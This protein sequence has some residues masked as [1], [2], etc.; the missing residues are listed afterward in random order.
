MK[1]LRSCFLKDDSEI[2]ESCKLDHLMIPSGKKGSGKISRR[3]FFIGTVLPVVAPGFSILRKQ[4]SANGDVTQLKNETSPAGTIIDT[5]THFFDPLRPVPAGRDRPIPWPTPLSSLYRQTLPPDWEALAKPL[6]MR[7]TIVV[8]AGTNWLEDNDWILMM[9]ERYHSIVGLI[10]NLSGTA[11]K[12]ETTVPV[13]DDMTRFR[14]EVR[15]LAKNSL[16]RGIRV[17]G[18]SVSGDLS[19]GRYPHF[20]VLADAGLVIEMLGVPAAEVVALTKKVPS[21][22]IVLDHMFNIS[23]VASPSPR[24]KSDIMAL[25]EQKNVVMKV[26][27]LVEGLDSPQTDSLAAFT[28]CRDA[29]DHVYKSFGPDRLVFGTNWPV[30]RFKGE[31][32]IVTDIVRRYFEPKGEDVLAM[33]FAGN[34]KKVYRYVD[35]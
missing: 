5:H 10:G 16:F 25:S 17:G 15:R 19:G 33:V 14:Q 28:L 1:K 20:E 27:G 6:G 34:A 26:S 9:A 29:I 13:W 21:L 22:T 30:S 4:F 35:R 18:T 23:E 24:W 3:R 12:N 7:G 11:I 8:E 31:M 2:I 32:S